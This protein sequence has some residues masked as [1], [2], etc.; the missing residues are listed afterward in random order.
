MTGPKIRC[1]G[2]SGVIC[3]NFVFGRKKSGRAA[4]LLTHAGRLLR[5]LLMAMLLLPLLLLV[6]LVVVLSLFCSAAAAFA[7][8]DFAAPVAAAAASADT[9]VCNFK[10][11][12]VF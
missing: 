2:L 3:A 8:S 10:T 11:L 6:L 12:R 1:G 5:P 4:L 7:A 9:Q